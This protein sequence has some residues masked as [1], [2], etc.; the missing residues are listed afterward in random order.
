MSDRTS[1]IVRG[2]CISYRAR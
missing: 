2:G 1:V